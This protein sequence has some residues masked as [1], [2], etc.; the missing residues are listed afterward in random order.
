MGEINNLSN[1]GYPSKGF[2]HG[3]VFHADDVFATALLK[4][5]NPDFK[6]KR[7]NDVPDDFDGIVYDIGGGRYDHH[8]PGA[9]IRVNGVPYAA[10]GLV[11]EDYGKYLVGEAYAEVFDREFVQAVDLTDNTGRKNLMSSVIHDMNPEWD[12]DESSDAAF[13]AAVNYAI[14]TLRTAFKHIHAKQR[15]YRVVKDRIS[16]ARHG[17]LL[18]GDY[19]PWRDSLRDTEINY[20]IYRSTRGGYCIQ[21]VPHNEDNISDNSF[22]DIWRG[23]R[24]AELEYLTGITGFNFCHKGGFLC[25][26]DT[27]D[28]AW[29][30]AELNQS[31]ICV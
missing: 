29:K 4:L 17:I 26:T 11:W 12:E 18:L 9:R 30:V 19:M 20:V 10:F 21:T 3:G 22:K 15:A 23:K 14:L 25:S 24:R 5:L 13:D 28:A 7:G 31:D 1:V 6:W 2:T 16:D 27:L 8:Q